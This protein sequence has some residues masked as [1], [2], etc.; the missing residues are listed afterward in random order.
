MT[1]GRWLAWAIGARA[2]EWSDT[3]LPRLEDV[4]ARLSAVMAHDEDGGADVD[5]RTGRLHYLGEDGERVLTP[6]DR[7]AVGELIQLSELCRTAHDRD[8]RTFYL[9]C[10]ERAVTILRG[11][12]EPH[13]A[14]DQE[15]AKFWA[16]WH[17]RGRTER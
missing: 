11:T 2:V 9:L 16:F 10:A 17:P 6:A 13:I 7:V 3:D 12:S 15:I 8:F 14:T 4:R 1:G 5:E